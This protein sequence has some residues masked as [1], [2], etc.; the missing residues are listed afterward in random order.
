[1]RRCSGKQG[2]GCA[3]F[4]SDWDSHSLCFSCRDY[5][6]DNPCEVCSAWFTLLWSKAS[7]AIAKS[8]SKRS[9]SSKAG[10]VVQ[11]VDSSRD[12]SLPLPA[13]NEGPVV[14]NHSVAGVE[15]SSSQAL[16]TG[17]N[18]GAHPHE[19]ST[20][21]NGTGNSSQPSCPRA[22]DVSSG[23]PRSRSSRSPSKDQTVRQDSRVQCSRNRSRR[24]HRS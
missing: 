21:G 23:A 3:Q 7:A 14:G 11:Q 22:P 15:V 5:S 6:Q 19:S 13:G 18:L 17:S 8:E 20:F 4:L 10:G 16:T 24:A 12:S 1:M 2:R 9:N